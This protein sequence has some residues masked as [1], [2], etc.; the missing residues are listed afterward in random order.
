VASPRIVEDLVRFCVEQCHLAWL[1]SGRVHS[2][3]QGAS[4]TV[5]LFPEIL[6]EPEHGEEAVLGDE[7]L[8]FGEEDTGPGAGPEELGQTSPQPIDVGGSDAIRTFHPGEGTETGAPPINLGEFGGQCVGPLAAHDHD[9]GRIG[10]FQ[11][12]HD[13]GLD[14]SALHE[15]QTRGW[16]SEGVRTHVHAR[17]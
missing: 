17:G 11:G 7:V 9:L 5:R 15:D 4:G 1:Q 14:L 13:E 12:M 2:D 8:E 6:D 3:S 10:P 16:G